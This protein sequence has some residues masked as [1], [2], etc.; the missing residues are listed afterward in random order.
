MNSMY[1]IGMIL[2]TIVLLKYV[3]KIDVKKAKKLNQNPEIEK[4][5]DRFPDNIEIAQEML[6]MI[7]NKNVKI[8]EIKNT[9]TSLYIALTNKILIA[10][11]KNNYAR[12]QT[13]AHECMHSIQDRRML[14]FNFVFSNIFIIFWITMCILTITRVTTNTWEI[15][16][17]LLLFTMLKIVVRGY[18]ETDAMLKSRYL[19]EHY[20]KQKNITSKEETEK[21]LDKYDEI[22]AVGVPYTIVRILLGSLIGILVF[23]IITLFMARI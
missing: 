3:F 15:I 10:D 5:I 1:A 2:V 12:I 23:L 20:I 16:F 11:L 19:A 8:E 9:Q 7:D 13:I 17:I 18:L 4:I 22:N 21:I 6:E 14:M